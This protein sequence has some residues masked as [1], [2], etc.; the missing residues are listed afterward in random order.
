MCKVMGLQGSVGRDGQQNQGGA[1]LG[2]THD[3]Q[4]GG[5]ARGALGWEETGR[6]LL[7]LQH[8]MGR[9][10]RGCLYATPHDWQHMFCTD[11][12][13]EPFGLSEP[14]GP[15]WYRSLLGCLRQS[16]LCVSLLLE[17]K[18]HAQYSALCLY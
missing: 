4:V 12:P 11:A 8:H 5:A 13:S 1:G 2:V 15:S 18:A 3:Q 9:S 16:N 7:H 17:H 6:G 10:A 14:V